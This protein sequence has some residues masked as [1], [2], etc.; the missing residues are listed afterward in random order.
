MYETIGGIDSYPDTGS[1]MKTLDVVQRV[2]TCQE[3]IENVAY[4]SY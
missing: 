1:S 4:G 2:T 3:T